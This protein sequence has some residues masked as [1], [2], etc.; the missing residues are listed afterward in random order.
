MHCIE[1]ITENLKEFSKGCE[2]IR[3]NIQNHIKSIN[4]NISNNLE[5]TDEHLFI[6]ISNIEEV[7]RSFLSLLLSNFSEKTKIISNGSHYF[8]TI[9][10]LKEMLPFSK[11]AKLHSYSC[12]Y[13]TYEISFEKEEKFDSKVF[14]NA[15]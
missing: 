6:L 14:E 12:P 4:T 9:E 15:T 7:K 13:Y 1:D 5:P 8:D 11:E 3:N 2:F 10:E